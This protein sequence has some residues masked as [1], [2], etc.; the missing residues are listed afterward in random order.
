MGTL[1][2]IVM[3][4]FVR[5]DIQVQEQT[6]PPLEQM[7]VVR[8]LA[9]VAEGPEGPAVT[10][11]VAKMK[12]LKVPMVQIIGGELVPATSHYAPIRH[13]TLRDV[14]YALNLNKG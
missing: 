3:D 12:L 9:V 7:L 5:M 4:M 2:P 11:I 14:A 6:H 1:Q 10:V 13:V 8:R